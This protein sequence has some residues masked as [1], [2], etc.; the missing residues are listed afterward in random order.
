MK[1]FFAKRL[2]SL[3]GLGRFFYFKKRL[4]AVISF[5]KVG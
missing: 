2:A 1:G 4:T 3:R 5:D